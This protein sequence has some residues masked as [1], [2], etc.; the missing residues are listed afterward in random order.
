MADLTAHQWAE[1]TGFSKAADWAE[2]RAA[3]KEQHWVALK[4][5]SLAATKVEQW[6][7]PMVD[8]MVVQKAAHWVDW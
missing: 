1:P 8:V 7:E 2:L 6:E 5:N 4:G 3:Q